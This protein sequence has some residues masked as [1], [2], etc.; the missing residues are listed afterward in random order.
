VCNVCTHYE[1]FA[2]NFP[3]EAAQKGWKPWGPN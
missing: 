3:N 2:P 1:L